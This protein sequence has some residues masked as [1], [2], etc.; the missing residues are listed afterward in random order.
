MSELAADTTRFLEH[1]K[2]ERHYSPGTLRNYTHALETL[3]RFTDD[4]SLAAWS[5]LRGDQLQTLVANGPRPGLE[6]PSLRALPAAYRRV[7]RFRARGG[8]IQHAPAAGVRSPK[9][10]GRLPDVLDVDEAAALVEATA[11]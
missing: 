10:R 4:L 11:S 8:T 7:F 9:V 3:T 5:D 6:P 1:L 2:V